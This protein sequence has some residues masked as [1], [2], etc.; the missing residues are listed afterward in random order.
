MNQISTSQ[1][2]KFTKVVNT[3]SDSVSNY[4]VIWRKNNGEIDR[5]RE[6]SNLTFETI[7]LTTLVDFNAFRNWPQDV[8]SET[9]SIDKEYCALY[10]NKAYL[11]KNE[12]LSD[13]GN[14]NFDPGMDRFI[15]NGV[16]Y[17][18]S[19]DTLISQTYADALFYLL[20]LERESYI[21]AEEPR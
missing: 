18:P 17:K 14:L 13:K 4:P 15:I 11:L 3:F 8:R 19:G 1:W 10:L 20:I 12:W 7:N 6:Q 16:T 21:T 9:G 5:H 2:E